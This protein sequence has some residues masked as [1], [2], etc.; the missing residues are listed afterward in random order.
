MG[1]GDHYH[2]STVVLEKAI[3]LLPLSTSYIELGRAYEAEG[4]PSVAIDC[5]KQAGF[6]VPSR[7][8][9]VYLTMKLYYINGE[10]EKAKE[11]AE[12]LLIKKIKIDNP[13][14]DR[15]KHEAMDIR[16]CEKEF[17]VMR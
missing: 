13:E 7:F 5:W 12:Q 16:R 14:I 9:P 8:T 17:P 11:Y 4:F 3:K 1:F 2:E 10:C 15:M 6:M